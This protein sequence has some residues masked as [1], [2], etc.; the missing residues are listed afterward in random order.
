MD[1]PNLS[2]IFA[3]AI[4]NGLLTGFKMIWW[5]FPLAIIIKIIERWLF[6]KIDN[7][8][9]RRRN[10]KIKGFSEN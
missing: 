6:K 1:S 2:S 3:E 4:T 8:K 10:K 9:Y 7:W 5:L